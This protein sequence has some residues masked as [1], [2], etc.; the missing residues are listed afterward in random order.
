MGVP[1]S[2]FIALGA[3][4]PFEQGRPQETL[5]RV[6]Q[7]LPSQGVDVIRVS[8]FWTSPAWPDPAKPDYVNAIAQI[9]T[10]KIA[11]ELLETLQAVEHK[12]GRRRNERWDS[13]TLDLDLIDYK[14]EISS[15]D[16]LMLPHP[17]LSDRAFVLLPLA[18]IA[19]GWQHPVSGQ[20]VSALINALDETS[21][22]QTIR[23]V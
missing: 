13:R 12:F 19:P 18:E 2:I 3:N 15:A 11:L 4:L 22:S 1:A 23:M 7:S 8:S 21:I 10:N 20:S 9:A 6:L 5:S 14:G 17:R 16:R